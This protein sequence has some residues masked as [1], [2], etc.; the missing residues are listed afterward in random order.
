MWRIEYVI[1]PLLIIFGVSCSKKI[2][3]TSWEKEDEVKLTYRPV[4]HKCCRDEAN[5]LPDPQ[6]T[7]LIRCCFHYI[8]DDEGNYN[9][10]HDE[11]RQ[12]A[13]DLINSC[14]KV[15]KKVVTPKL[16]TEEG[17]DGMSKHYK[18]VI[19]PATNE[20]GDDGIYFHNDSE[21]FAFVAYGR[22]ANNYSTKVVKKYAIQTDSF[23][24]IFM[25]T[26]H[27]DSVASPTYK[28]RRNG[29]ALGSSLKVAGYYSRQ[30]SP[31]EMHGI[32]NHEIGHI[33]G[34][35][36]TW[37][38]NDGCDDTPKHAN[39]WNY[40][41]EPPCDKDLSNNMMDYNAWQD[42]LTPCQISRIH[43]NLT[44]WSTVQ[45][46]FAVA[47][48]CENM[49][50]TLIQ[51]DEVWEREKD[52]RGDIIIS[53]GATL[54]LRCRTALPKDAEIRV[55]PGATLILD[56]CWL[57]NSCGDT[58]KGIRIGENKKAKGI[59]ETIGKVKIENVESELPK[60]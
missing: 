16:Q 19:M 58:W 59:V 35:G 43:R 48:W 4:S 28:A 44:R 30:R 34:L 17:V 23:I 10:P 53:E 51:Y 2:T 6:D 11:A 21:N 33:L 8:Y 60:S 26:H 50:S 13:H 55:E 42:A 52:V 25:M 12:F 3:Y 32:T 38:G 20:V 14:N 9:L 39:C 31:A 27:P 15:L 45:R 57:H 29:I 56:N 24:N 1:L 5:Y 18:Y 22:N 47:D 37:N 7:I 40:T 46:K 36:H 41:K 54:T 49:K